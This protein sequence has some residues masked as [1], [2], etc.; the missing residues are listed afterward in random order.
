MRKLQ[1]LWNRGPWGKFLIGGGRKK[2]FEE[3]KI[4]HVLASL[5]SLGRGS[6]QKDGAEAILGGTKKLLGENTNLGRR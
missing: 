2:L 6:K 4:P 5:V 1:V 3:G